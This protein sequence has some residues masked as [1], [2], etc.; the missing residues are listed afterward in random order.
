MANKMGEELKKH[1]EAYAYAVRSGTVVLVGPPDL[2]SNHVMFSENDLKDAVKEGALHK[3]A[4]TI[5]N[6]TGKSWTEEVYVLPAS[7]AS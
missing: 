7:T 3:T 5:S 1:G 2:R 6:H 4:W